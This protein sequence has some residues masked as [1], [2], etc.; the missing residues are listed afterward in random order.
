MKNIILYLCFAASLI[1]NWAVISSI[2]KIDSELIV[3]KQLHNVQQY[4]LQ[5]NFSENELDSMYLEYN[6]YYLNNYYENNY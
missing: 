1:L 6:Y 2:D 3:V 5:D 4:M